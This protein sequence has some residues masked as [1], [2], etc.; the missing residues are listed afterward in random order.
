MAHIGTLQLNY[1]KI[2]ISKRPLGPESLIIF[3]WDALLSVAA[4]NGTDILIPFNKA[5]MKL[6]FSY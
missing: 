1:K 3:C 4:A 6:A 5:S 2:K